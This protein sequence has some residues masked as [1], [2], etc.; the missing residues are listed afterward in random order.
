M[1][2]VVLDR[3]TVLQR[4]TIVSM[5]LC[6]GGQKPLVIEACGHGWTPTARARDRLRVSALYGP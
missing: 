6:R 2:V 1:N 4:G 3:I 5:A